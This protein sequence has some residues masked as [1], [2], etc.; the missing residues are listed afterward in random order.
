MARGDLTDD[1]WLRL[2]AVLPPL[3]TMGR[4]PRDRRQ[5]FDGIWWRARTGSPWR[6]IPER[7][8]PW[9]TSYSAFRRWQIDGTWARVLEKLQVKA[10]AA[11]HVEWEVSVDSTVCRAHQHAAGARKKGADREGRPDDGGLADEPA[12][13]GL[14][15]SRGGLST[16][17]HLAADAAGHVLAI[18]VTGGQRG[19][20]PQF[21]EVMDRI[22]V[23]RPG[24]GRP[25]VRPDHVLADRAYSSREIRAYLRRRNIAHTIPEKRD[26]AG[27]RRSRGSA[28]GRPPGFDREKY[29][30]RHKVECRIGLLKQA[31][32]VA[33]RYD[34]L[35]VRYEATVQLALIR[36]SL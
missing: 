30:A 34:K 27:H 22:R 29:K 10:D 7:Y 3:P 12:D 23:P 18:V 14:G 19:D 31:R 9:E 36:Q 21:I 6:D 26:Q 25:R 16:K 33:T 13:H 24:G 15:R 8:G 28:G 20:A 2:E 4:K 35:A 1:Q 17:L 5:V 11:G 32:G